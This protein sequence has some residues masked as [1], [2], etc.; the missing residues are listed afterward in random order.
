MHFE[1]PR[2]IVHEVPRAGIRLDMQFVQEMNGC[3]F[4]ISHRCAAPLVAGCSPSR[5]SNTFNA[6]L[7]DSIGSV[8]VWYK[9]IPAS[10]IAAQRCQRGW[11]IWRDAGP[12][13]LQGEQ[14][15]GREAHLN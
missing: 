6:L 2:A 12:A 7:I 15:N 10:M 5:S 8:S 1:I 4:V 13:W 9:S 14:S 3:S 11:R